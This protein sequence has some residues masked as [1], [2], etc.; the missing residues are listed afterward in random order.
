MLSHIDRT[1][2]PLLFA[3]NEYIYVDTAKASKA[4]QSASGTTIS[5]VGIGVDAYLVD[6]L[7]VNLELNKPIKAPKANSYGLDNSSN[8]KKVKLFAGL[9]Y[10][11]SF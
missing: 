1:N 10:M 9:K 5:S 4:P 3:F 6:N 7:I 2:H 11:F 8:S